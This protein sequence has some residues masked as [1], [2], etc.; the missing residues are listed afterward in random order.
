[1]V[2]ADLKAAD[3]PPF[4]AALASI[5]QAG[6]VGWRRYVEIVLDGLRARP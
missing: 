4:Y 5:V 2:R 1:V 6:V 3:M